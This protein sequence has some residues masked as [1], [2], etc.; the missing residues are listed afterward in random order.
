MKFNGNSWEYVGSKGFSAGEAFYTNIALN[1]N[2]TPYVVYSDDGNSRKATVMRFN[3]SSWEYVG[4]HGFSNPYV[5]NTNIAIN[6]N[7]IPYVVYGDWL[8]NYKA[9]VMKVDTSKIFDTQTACDSLTWIDGNTYTSSNNT[10]TYILTNAV[11]CDSIV[12][13]I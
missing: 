13:L 3:G 4:I 2:N 12:T 9:T 11:G 10:A 6:S 1:T 5:S 7:N 8:N